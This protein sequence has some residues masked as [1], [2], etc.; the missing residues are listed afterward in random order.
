MPV[1][2]KKKSH[3]RGIVNPP[4]EQEE[5]ARQV[6]QGIEKIQ[7]LSPALLLRTSERFLQNVENP[8]L[9]RDALPAYVD[10]IFA[11]HAA[12]LLFHYEGVKRDN[13]TIFTSSFFEASL[14]K[15]KSYGVLLR[16]A[17]QPHVMKFLKEF[18]RVFSSLNYSSSEIVASHANVLIEIYLN[19]VIEIVFDAEKY[20]HSLGL[21]SIFP[22][23]ILGDGVF[24]NKERYAT[25]VIDEFKKIIHYLAISEELQFMIDPLR[26]KLTTVIREALQV[27]YQTKNKHYEII[28]NI[29]NSDL[30]R[31]IGNENISIPVVHAL[32]KL[33]MFAEATNFDN[34]R[35]GV[36]EQVSTAE[37][38]HN[39]IIGYLGPI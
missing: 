12:A 21:P 11:A 31:L 7:D 2:H 23:K 24:E 38:I 37:D 25:A 28:I 34:R 5:I 8:S 22:K 35:E 32:R 20:R 14:Q 18:P 30:L 29:V 26:E 13:T 15:M 3:R 16:Q 10:S 19:D 36:E 6:S 39:L 33:G 4:N 27:A 9:R 1:K 17:G